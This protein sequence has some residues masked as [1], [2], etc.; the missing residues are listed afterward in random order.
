MNDQVIKIEF[1]IWAS[2][3]AEVA[4]LKKEICSFI[5]WHGQQGRKVT[6]SKLTEAIRR[7]QSN[8][9][10]RQSIINHFR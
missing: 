3:E 1:N 6:A 8:P 9:I 7:W 2:N 10:V 5:D 4:E